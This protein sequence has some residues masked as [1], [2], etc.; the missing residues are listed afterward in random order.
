[1]EVTKIETAELSDMLPEPKEVTDT[2]LRAEYRY[3][4]SLERVQ[5]LL[6]A[7]YITEKEAAVIRRSLAEKFSPTIDGILSKT[8]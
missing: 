3:Q 6:S 7:G 1:M 8:T 2:D 4:C 5:K